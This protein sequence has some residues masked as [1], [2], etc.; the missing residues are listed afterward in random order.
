M[1][2]EPYRKRTEEITKD[3]KFHSG[4]AGEKSISENGALKDMAETK[5]RFEEKTTESAAR[6]DE[7]KCA[8]IR[9]TIADKILHL[10]QVRPGLTEVEIAMGLFGPDAYQQRVNWQCRCLVQRRSI[11]RRGNGG[12]DEA[13]RYYPIDTADRR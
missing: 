8:T 7:K 4:S 5:V 3:Q 13:Y 9:D 1:T 12:L 11:V 10:V 2:T 6:D